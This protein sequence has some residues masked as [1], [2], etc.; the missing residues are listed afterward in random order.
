MEHVPGT[1][2]YFNDPERPA[3]R[4]GWRH[5][6]QVRHQRAYAHH[7]GQL[8]P[9]CARERNEKM[10]RSSAVAL[11]APTVRRPKRPPELALVEARSD[12]LCPVGDGHFRDGPRAHP[13]RQHRHPVA[14]V[15]RRL[16]QD[17]PVDGLLSARLRLCGRFFC[18]VE[19]YL[20][21]ATRLLVRHLSPDREQRLGGGHRDQ[22]QEPAGGEDRPRHGHGPFEALVNAAVGDLYFVHVRATVVSTPL[23]PPPFV[24]Y[25]NWGC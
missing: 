6:P 20:G 22:L 21:Q 8:L 16:H 5:C 15:R 25:A 9:G 3:V 24:I 10:W 1:T 11:G 17:R 2:R 23:P 14:V 19:P 13:R 4:R 18:A 7:P 12:M